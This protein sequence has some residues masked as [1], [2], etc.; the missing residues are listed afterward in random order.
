MRIEL[1]AQRKRFVNYGVLIDYV[2]LCFLHFVQPVLSYGCEIWGLEHPDSWR[3]MSSIHHMFMKHTLHVR[4]STPSDI[5]LCELKYVPKRKPRT[6][7]GFHVSLVRFLYISSDTKYKLQYVGRLAD[8][9]D[10]RLVKQAFT[11]AQQRN[12]ITTRFQKLSS[13]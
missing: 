7:P 4:R 3:Q 9:P 1:R 12:S 6:T 2:A 13:W 11:H 8:L 5:V 10:D